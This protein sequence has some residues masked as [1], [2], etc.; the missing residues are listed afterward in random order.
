MI[1]TKTAAGRAEIEQ[2]TLGLSALSRRALIL[3]DGKR[4]IGELTPV[5]GA[6]V[7]LTAVVRELQENGLIS[8]VD[9]RHEVASQQQAIDPIR[10][11]D[12]KPGRAP[13]PQAATL[14][15]AKAPGIQSEPLIAEADPL[16]PIVL[17]QVQAILKS[18]AT[19][20]LGLL[21]ADICRRVDAARDRTSLMRCIAKWNMAMRE[22]RDGREMAE[23]YLLQV[24]AL[25]ED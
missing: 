22:G 2:R 12:A 7:E 4:S 17:A 25:M 18:T 5:F 15:P 23:R 20:Y 24:K 19:E 14:A 21:G 9:G 11:P 16:S 1:Y 6:G 3:M 13:M 10:L 8:V